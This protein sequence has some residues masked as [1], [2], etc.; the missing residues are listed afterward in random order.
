MRKITEHRFVGE[1]EIY[2]NI[3]KDGK[4]DGIVSYSMPIVYVGNHNMDELLTFVLDGVPYTATRAQWYKALSNVENNNKNN[5]L[6]RI[7]GDKFYNQYFAYRHGQFEC[8]QI[9]KEYVEKVILKIKPV[10]RYS[11]ADIKLN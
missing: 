1:Y 2:F 6:R 10:N 9:A 11:T 8:E 5:I 3:T 7:V 4:T